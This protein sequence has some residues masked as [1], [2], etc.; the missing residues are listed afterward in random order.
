[1]VWAGRESGEKGGK[2]MGGE[3]SEEAYYG[4]VL[5]LVPDH[6]LQMKFYFA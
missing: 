3:V 5:G 2:R 1:M 6:C 4:N